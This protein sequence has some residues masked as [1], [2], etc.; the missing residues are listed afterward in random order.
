MNRVSLLTLFQPLDIC[1]LPWQSRLSR[2][3]PAADA[4]KGKRIFAE[5]CASCHDALGTTTK[6]GPALKSYYRRQPRPADAA[7]RAI[8]EQGRGRMPPFTSLGKPQVD[9]LVAYLK[10]L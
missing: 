9:D 6:S 7:V 3:S 10:T 1:S 5:S 8:I 2:K 4:A